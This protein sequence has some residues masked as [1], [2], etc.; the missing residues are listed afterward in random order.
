VNIVQAECTRNPEKPRKPRK[1]D[2]LWSRADP[3][4][5]RELDKVCALLGDPWKR[6]TVVHEIVRLFLV[7]GHEAAANHIR[8][9]LGTTPIAGEQALAALVKLI[10][11]D[12][13]AIDAARRANQARADASEHEQTPPA[14]AGDQPG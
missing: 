7:P 10:A 3:H 1:S 13:Q 12:L 4:L 6:S 8:M 11:Q 5:S 2:R 14:D 9:G